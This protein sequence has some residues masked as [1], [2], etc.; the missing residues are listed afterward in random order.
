VA[1]SFIDGGNWKFPEK[2]TDISHKL[3]LSH[4]VASST[5]HHENKKVENHNTVCPILQPS[6]REIMFMIQ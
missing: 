5:P 2:T 4:N 1:V 6:Y 3:L